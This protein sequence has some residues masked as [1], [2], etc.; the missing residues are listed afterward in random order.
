MQT[1]KQSL[2]E[3][4]INILIGFVV[5]LFIGIFIFKITGIQATYTQNF[6][7]TTLFT[8][9]SFIRQYIIRRWFNKREKHVQKII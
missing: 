8:I 3:S 4:G 5:A 6:M 1:K 2:I 9:A 7:S